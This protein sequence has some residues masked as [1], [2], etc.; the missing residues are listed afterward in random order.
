MPSHAIIACTHRRTA[1]LCMLLL[2]AAVLNV[3]ALSMHTL[4][5]TVP[6]NPKYL[7]P[8]LTDNV[9]LNRAASEMQIAPPWN[10]PRWLWSTAWKL[11]TWAV[12]HL[13]HKW[14]HCIRTDSFLNLSVL[15]WK[16]ISGNRLGVTNDRGAA[17]ALLPPWTRGIVAFPLCYLYPNLHHQNVALRT[18]FMDRCLRDTLA[19]H[20]G[21]SSHVVAIT[22]GAGFDTRSLRFLNDYSGG[23]LDMYE[24]DLPAVTEEKSMVLQRRYLARRPGHRLPSL[25]GADLNDVGALSRQLDAIFVE[26]ARKQ[27]QLREGKRV[28]VILLVEAV[29]MYVGDDAVLPALQACVARA[30]DFS[31]DTV[32]IF[33]DRFPGI[34]EALG[35]ANVNKDEEE[36]QLVEGFLSRAGLRLDNWTPKPGRARHMGTAFAM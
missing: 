34:L 32:F 2:F 35:A 10:A 28:K 23:S 24:L 16:A 3:D 14:D 30:K 8:R 11:Q 18:L 15:W 27:P 9:L 21:G 36:R 13:L 33:S 5:R 12:K 4:G 19:Q 20:E 7:Q 22:L 26:A 6:T 25:Y 29:F 1:I 17:Y 31:K